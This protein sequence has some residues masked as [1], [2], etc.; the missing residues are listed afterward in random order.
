MSNTDKQTESV[1]EESVETSA[2]SYIDDAKLN[3]ALSNR[4]KRWEKKQAELFNSFK[5]ELLGH[6]NAPKK[7]AASEKAED[8]SSYVSKAEFD[9]L[10][11]KYALQE[12]ATQ[13][14]IRTSI[15][16]EAYTELRSKLS[17]KVKPEAVDA[18]ARLLYHADKKVIVDDDGELSWIDGEDRVDLDS[19]LKNWMKSREASIFLSAPLPT[20]KQDVKK[21]VLPPSTLQQTSQSKTF[22]EH[23]N[24]KQAAAYLEAERARIRTSKS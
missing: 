3:A 16:K 8:K 22:T 19:G 12:E 18:V 17:D 23:F 4:D 5:E 1:V 14:A 15:E 2:P 6:I 24:P 13:K 7:E 10:Q 21:A 9:K 20:K 11:R